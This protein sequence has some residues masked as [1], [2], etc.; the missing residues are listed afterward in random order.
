MLDKTEF[1]DEIQTMERIFIGFILVFLIR[2]RVKGGSIER[3]MFHCT[4]VSA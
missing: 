3:K 2:G 1:L 4:E